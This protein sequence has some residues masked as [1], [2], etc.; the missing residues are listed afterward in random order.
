M[1][2][3]QSGCPDPS[4]VTWRSLCTCCVCVLVPAPH[5]APSGCGNP[6]NRHQELEPGF[7]WMLPNRQVFQLE[8]A[9]P[10]PRRQD[11]GHWLEGWR[12]AGR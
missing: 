1:D 12:D 10:L 2:E 7:G 8:S 6:L 9:Q 11:G 5:P 3:V 4:G